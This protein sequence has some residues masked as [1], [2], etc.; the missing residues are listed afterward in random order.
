M[1]G[2]KPVIEQREETLRVSNLTASNAL[3][4]AFLLGWM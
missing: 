2:T 1:I 3:E 4:S